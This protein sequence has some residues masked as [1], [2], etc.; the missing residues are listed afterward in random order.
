ML[1]RLLCVLTLALTACGVMQPTSSLTPL[2]YS[3]DF[4]NPNSGWETLSDLNADVTY[5][6]GTL[7]IVIKRE[8]LIQWSAAGQRFGDGVRGGRPAQGRADG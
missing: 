2:P 4:S 5:D 8:N 7:R 6:A 1:T 3:D